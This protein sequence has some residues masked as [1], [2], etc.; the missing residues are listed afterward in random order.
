VDVFHEDFNARL[1][2]LKFVELV[3]GVFMDG[4]SYSG[5]DCDE[6]V[7]FPSDILNIVD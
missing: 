3:N 7:G 2:D 6:A 4:S 5:G 1:W